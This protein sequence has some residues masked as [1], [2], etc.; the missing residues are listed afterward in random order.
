[1]LFPLYFYYPLRD[2][3]NKKMVILSW[4]IPY[5][6]PTKNIIILGGKDKSFVSQRELFWD[7]ILTSYIFFHP[8]LLQ[9]GHVCLTADIQCITSSYREPYRPAA[10]SKPTVLLM[11]FIKGFEAITMQGEMDQLYIPSW[12]VFSPSLHLSLSLSLP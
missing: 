8:F 10:P 11:T 12:R 1:M 9:P 7:H 2:N 6:K 5:I 3:T 4:T